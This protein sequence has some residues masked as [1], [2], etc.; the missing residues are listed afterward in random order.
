MTTTTTSVLSNVVKTA[1]DRMLYFDLRSQPTY[2]MICDV[3]PALQAMPGNVVT[4]NIMSNLSAATSTL[5]ETSDV[6]PV[7]LATSTVSA[8]L[9]EYGN[10]VELS[11]FLRATGF[12]DVDEGTLNVLGYN[13]ADSLDQ[14]AVG[15]LDQGSNVR[16]AG[17]AA[18]RSSLTPA[19]LIT[20]AD[21]RYITAKLR[22]NK[23]VPRKQSYYVAFVHP[24]VSYDLRAQT[25]S[26]ANASWRESHIYAS[27]EAIYAGEIG[28]FEGAAFIETPRAPI[29]TDAGSSPT[30]TD[31]YL[32][33]FVGQQA[34]AKA[35]AIDPHLVQSPVVDR[36][37]RLVNYGWYALLGYARFREAAIY[38]FES[39]SSIGAN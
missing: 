2:D 27:P 15:I 38:R 6:S 16:Y 35:V 11:A 34:L 21:V 26:A 29:V 5:S 7:T 10:A 19:T 4:W 31:V 39:A 24:D 1:Y 22:G 8:T 13:L 9:A 14:V 30:T 23:A 17:A 3:K 33:M 12:I 37:R 18:G 28:A 25:S 20:A 32:S 36:L